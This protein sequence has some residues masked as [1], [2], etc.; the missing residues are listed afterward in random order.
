MENIYKSELGKREVLGQYRTILASWPVEN[1]Q[2]EVETSLGPTFVIESGSKDTPPLILLHGS[3]SNSYT[4]YGDVVSLSKTYNVYAIDIIGEAGLSA[5]SRPSY[6]SGA[7][8]LWLNET[9]HALRLSTCSI[10]AMS[11]GGWMALS[12]ATTYPDKVDKLVLLCPGGLA[13]EKAS[14]LWKAIFFSLLGKWGQLQTLKLVGGNMSSSSLSELGEGLT[15]AS[16]TF[17][18]FKPRT[19]KMPL[20]SDQSLYQLTMPILMLF[21]D[22]DQLIPASKSI[23][24]LKQFAQ[25]ARIE[26]LPDTGHLIVNQADRIL[27]FL[28]LQGS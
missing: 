23:N 28:N 5:A 20:I 1:H 26:L 17:K 4:W 3:V 2:Y 15:F 18:Y 8:A 10:V 12:F 7:Y 16:L 13:H 6:K 19:A 27:K 14:F 25:Q 22:S 9:L 11:L 24:R 21:G